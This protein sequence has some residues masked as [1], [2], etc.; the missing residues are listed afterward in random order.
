[1]IMPCL[2]VRQP[3]ALAIVAGWKPWENRSR[4][5]NYRGP[6]LIHA[7]K[8]STWDEYDAARRVVFR[9]CGKRTPLLHEVSRGGIVGAAMLTDCA[10]PLTHDGEWRIAGQYG[11][12]MERAMPLPFR[13]LGG[14]LG[15]F[16][17]E[18]TGAEELALR[19]RGLV[20]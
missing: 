6:L 5:F 7:S 17:V 13:A 2:S 12:R 9:I 20:P 4:R 11:L 1:M 8:G 14:K 16:K 3:W 15:L 10:D 18:L 19:A